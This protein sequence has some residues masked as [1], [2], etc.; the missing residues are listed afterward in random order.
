[1]ALRRASPLPFSLRGISQKISGVAAVWEGC[2]IRSFD[3]AQ[4]PFGINGQSSVEGS[5]AS[6]E[7]VVAQTA[8]ACSLSVSEAWK[9]F[10]CQHARA[11]SLGVK[12]MLG[13][14][15]CFLHILLVMGLFIKGWT[16]RQVHTEQIVKWSFSMRI[17][18]FC[19]LNYYASLCTQV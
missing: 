6:A 5:P 18:F 10:H 9:R 4:T 17:M 2:R 7:Y 19:I 15:D 1:M 3:S 8:L 16:H 12:Y 11:F 13:L 14:G